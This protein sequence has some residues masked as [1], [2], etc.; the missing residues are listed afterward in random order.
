V[1]DVLRIELLYSPVLSRG[2]LIEISCL[3]S[4][5]WNGSSRALRDFSDT[6]AT[7]RRPTE[8]TCGLIDNSRPEVTMNSFE[9]S[10]VATPNAIQRPCNQLSEEELV[11]LT[12]SGDAEAF[13]VIF[14]R[15]QQRLFRTAVRITGN[16]SDAEDVV[17]EALLRAYKKIATFRFS[18]SLLTWLT[19]IVVNCALMEHRRRKHRTSLSLDGVNEDGISLMELI[20][21][22][23]AD[24]EE[25]LCLKE[26]SQLLTVCIT[27]LPPHL[28]KI[29][30]DYRMS[31]P[32]MAELAQSHTI[33]VAA[34][35]S[36]LAR[37]RTT[38]KNS[39]PIVN[40]MRRGRITAT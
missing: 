26:E 34:A 32:T 19:Q 14:R 5:K 1:P 6:V 12:A 8:E 40:A 30:E 10:I 7:T 11:A 22:P 31:E 33:T 9:S 21:D 36:R 20:R 37:A 28:R 17:Q 16:A 24:A 39:G 4:Q 27:Q 25:D 15:Y 3:K 18:S 2:P 35:K 13:A 29:I 38:I 23:A